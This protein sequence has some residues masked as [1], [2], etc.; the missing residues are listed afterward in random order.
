MMVHKK[1]SKVK[2]QRSRIHYH[3]REGDH[4]CKDR[5]KG[6]NILHKWSRGQNVTTPKSMSRVRVVM[7]PSLTP[8][9]VLGPRMGDRIPSM[10][11][12][13]GSKTQENINILK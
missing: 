5:E 9:S 11:E 4:W 12:I 8:R 6:V 10:L 7:P 3:P 13:K 2:T 1:E